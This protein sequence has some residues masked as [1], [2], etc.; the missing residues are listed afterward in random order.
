MKYFYITLIIFL[1]TF[2]VYGHATL[3]ITG[4]EHEK[5]MLDVKIY[6]DKKSFLNEELA[7]ES[8]RKK[9]TKNKTIVPLTK[10]HEGKIAIVIYHDENNDGK[11]NTGLFW[12]PK[13]GY[14]FSNKYIPKGPPRFKKA[15]IELIHGK[16][17]TIKLNY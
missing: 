12:R 4:I 10:I 11:L 3:I 14:A 6:N 8:V 5:G 15:I 1:Y 2:N 9:P 17:V 7:I 13:E 16:P